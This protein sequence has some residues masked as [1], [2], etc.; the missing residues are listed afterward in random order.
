MLDL[1]VLCSVLRT[2]TLLL[3]LPNHFDIL[4][5][6]FLNTIFYEG[7]EMQSL[8]VMFHFDAQS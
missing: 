7:S 1:T 3:K 4:L 2:F 5:H 6:I 8:F